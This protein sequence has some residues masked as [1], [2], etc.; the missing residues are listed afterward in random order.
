MRLSKAD[1]ESQLRRAVLD[2]PTMQ[3][4]VSTVPPEGI[5]DEALEQ[6]RKGCYLKIPF[7][8]EEAAWAKA[9][10]SLLRTGD[11]NLKPYPCRWCS[12][13]GHPRWHLGHRARDMK[14]QPRN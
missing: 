10:G 1:R 2:C 4:E 3:A 14:N 13:P 6:W 12:R 8:S 9:I 5:S 11:R 7:A